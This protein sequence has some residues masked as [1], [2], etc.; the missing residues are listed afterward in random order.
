MSETQTLGV[1][2]NRERQSFRDEL[3]RRAGA[4][5]VSIG[6]KDISLDGIQAGEVPRARLTKE[7]SLIFPEHA[8]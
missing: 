5:A 6:G 1:C 7:L 8:C 4:F 2:G 3:S